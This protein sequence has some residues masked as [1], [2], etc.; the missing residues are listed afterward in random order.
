MKIGDEVEIILLDDSIIIGRLLEK[1]Q[2]GLII[3]K[4]ESDI[5]HSRDKTIDIEI[6]IPN[7]DIKKIN[8]RNQPF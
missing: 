2:I 8:K 4:K 6:F 7:T 5:F 3:K 1:N